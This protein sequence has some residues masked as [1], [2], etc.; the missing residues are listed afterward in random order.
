KITTLYE[1]RW[2]NGRKTV[3]PWG[4]TTG[5]DKLRKKD[6]F[7]LKPE[8]HKSIIQPSHPTHYPLDISVNPGEII[9]R[10]GDTQG[11]GLS[12]SC[13]AEDGNPYALGNFQISIDEPMGRFPGWLHKKVYGAK[14]Q[15]SSVIFGQLNNAG[16]VQ[17]FWI[18]PDSSTVLFSEGVPRRRK[19]GST[20]I[21]SVEVN[22]R[23]NPAYYGNIIILDGNYRPFDVV[24]ST[25][26]I[27]AYET[28]F[29]NN[30]STATLE[31]PPAVGTVKVTRQGTH[32]VESFLASPDT[33]QFYVDYN[34][35]KV[36]VKGRIE[37]L[38]IEYKPTYAFIN[39]RNPYRIQFYH[40]KV[41]GSYSGPILIG[42]D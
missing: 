6:V 22:Y 35:G 33:N 9:A 36:I 42:Y 13:I 20:A 7:N 17:F 23:V 10:Q 5:K 27:N 26:N 38:V 29:T 24:S 41:F 3:I 16:S 32:L 25:T 21:T 15:L 34:G 40:D 18:P 12:V 30:Y 28:T 39:P 2:P 11:V 37:E 4:R 31:Y 19:S 8:K 14:E 1:W